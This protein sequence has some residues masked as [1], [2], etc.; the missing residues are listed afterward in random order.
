MFNQDVFYKYI[1]DNKGKIFEY[2]IHDCFTFVS[3]YYELVTG[4]KYFDEIKGKYKTVKGYL[5]RLKKLGYSSVYD[6]MESNFC[7]LS[8]DM[9][10]R[11]DVLMSADCLG[12]CDGVKG[13]FL[14]QDSY[15]F[16]PIK[17][18]RSGY[19]VWPR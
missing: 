8:L 3:G 2:G 5:G 10:K 14:H 11:G 7:S 4:K 1:E 12:L 6:L 13:I 16:V 15:A 9:V 18:C 17:E 19:I